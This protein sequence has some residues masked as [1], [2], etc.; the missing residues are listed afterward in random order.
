VGVGVGVG[1][2]VWVCVCV[3]VCGCV[4]VGVCVGVGH[5]PLAFASSSIKQDTANKGCIIITG[6][7][8]ACVAAFACCGPGGGHQL[9][10]GAFVPLCGCLHSVG[11]LI[12]C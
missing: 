5:L 10:P 9:L 1:V 12:F 11:W 2:W 8:R 3:C 4:G 6:C 7:V